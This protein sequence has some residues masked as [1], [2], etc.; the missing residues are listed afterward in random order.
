VWHPYHSKY[1]LYVSVIDGSGRNLLGEGF[2]QPQFRPDGNLL[3]VNG[4]GAANLANLVTMTSSGGDK[5]EVSNNAED[6]FPT[7]R[8][9]GAIVAYSSSSW[10]DGRTRLGIVNDMNS[11]G[12]DWIP[13][14]NAQIEGDYPF[15]MPDGRLVFNTCEFWGGGGSC[16]LYT[17]GAGGNA[18]PQ[19]LTTHESDTAPTGSG[20]RVA[21]MSSRD[22]N[23]EVY[24]VNMDGSGLKRLTNNSAQD[25]LPTFSPDGRS[26]AFVSNR[27]GPWAIWVMDSDGSDQRKLFDLGGG[28]GSGE[29]DWTRERISWAP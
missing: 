27:G 4:D 22:G 3:A 5:R 1:E 16:G 29:N 10:G 28:Y 20:S 7:W 13:M 21:F 26:I 9:D 17:V 18:T 11:R 24:R 25:G 12:Q 15:W 23:W 8:A 6:G 2:R 14:G 19:R